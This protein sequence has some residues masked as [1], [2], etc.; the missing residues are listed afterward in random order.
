MSHSLLHDLPEPSWDALY[1]AL[2]PLWRQQLRL[3]SKTCQARCDA[4]LRCATAAWA[5][6]IYD[7]RV[8]QITPKA[9]MDALA[10]RFPRCA[11]IELHGGDPHGLAAGLQLLPAG[12]WPGVRAV[13]WR[14]GAPADAV[15]LLSRLCPA[16][17][18]VAFLEPATATTAAAS[19]GHSGGGGASGRALALGAELAPVTSDDED[20]ESGASDEGA[21]AGDDDGCAAEGGGA[22]ASAACPALTSLVARGAA[23]DSAP[24]PA[25]SSALSPAR[26]C[27]AALRGGL[28][29]LRR[30]EVDL[31]CDLDAY[32]GLVKALPALSALT[33]LG[34]TW[35]G[36]ARGTTGPALPRPPGA[37][38]ELELGFDVARCRK[39]LEGWGVLNHVTRLSLG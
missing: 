36:P 33:S 7:S 28:P 27:V 16:L 29:S 4:R 30:L 15:R 17:E 25:D 13:A 20:T 37:L 12:A 1:E 2:H 3:A 8:A 31:G 18:E 24:P 9:P 14:G 32:S 34:V 6:S 26:A 23:A 39:M 35:S 38:R 5:R 10:T 22:D 19:E 11:S 21:N